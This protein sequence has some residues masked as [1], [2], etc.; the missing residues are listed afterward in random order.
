MASKR[1]LLRSINLEM[2]NGHGSAWR[3]GV[4]GLGRLGRWGSS[5][6]GAAAQGRAAWRGRGCAGR[7]AARDRGMRE[8]LA[9]RSAGHGARALAAAPG[10]ARSRAGRG[11]QGE[12][13]E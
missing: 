1:M 4:V 13:R 12:E 8:L 9:A 11:E 6:A 10:W 5:V 7:S 3:W 2:K